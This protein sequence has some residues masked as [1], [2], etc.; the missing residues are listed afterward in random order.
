MAGLIAGNGAMSN[1]KYVGIAPGVRLYSFKVLDA[2]GSG[3]TSD[4][5]EAIDLAVQY[6]RTGGD[7]RHQPVAGSSDL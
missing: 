5:I 7:R 2:Q 6:K 3:Y 1:G 4:V